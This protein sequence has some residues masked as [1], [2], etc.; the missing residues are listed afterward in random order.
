MKETYD[1][2]V[3][4]ATQLVRVQQYIRAN[5]TKAHLAEKHYV[6]V[7]AEYALSEVV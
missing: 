6:L 7:Q 3:R 4:D 5:P 1:H 2:I